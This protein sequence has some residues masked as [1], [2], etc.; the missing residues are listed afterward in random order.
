[1]INK[2]N[3]ENESPPILKKW[4]NLYWV[5]ML[6]LIGWLIVFYIFRRIFE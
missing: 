6:N 4:K 3:A 1:M 2:Q 5:V